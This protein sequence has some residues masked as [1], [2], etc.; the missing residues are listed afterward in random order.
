MSRQGFSKNS[1]VKI[2]GRI[3]SNLTDSDV[4]VSFLQSNKVFGKKFRR[5]KGQVLM[6]VLVFA[7]IGVLLLTALTSWA[8]ANVRVSKESFY[9]EQAIQIAEAG[10]DYYRWHLAHASQDFQDGTGTTTPY[11]HDFF[12][13]DGVKIGTFTLEIVP[14]IVGSTVVTIRSTGRV[15]SYPSVYRKI[16]T[17]LAIP[18]LAKYSI[19][20]NADIRFGAGT[21]VFG[22]IHSNGGI[23]FDGVAHNIVSSSR[24]TYDDPDHTGGNEYAVHT[25]MSPIDALPPAALSN[26]ADVFQAGRQMSVP[27]FDFTGLTSDLATIKTNAV[28]AG[29]YF[30]SSGAQG[31]LIVLKTNDTFDLYKVNSL[32]SPASNCTNSSNQ[33]GWGTWSIG[34]S[35]SSKTFLLNYSIPANG[36]IFVEDNVWV[37]G[38]ID[39]AR[40]TIASGKFP[41]NPATR[42]SITVN[43]NLL[44]TNYDSQDVLALIA[45]NNFNVGMVS[46][47]TLRIDAAI[48]AQNGRAGRYYYGGPG[49]NTC[50]PYHSR[51][52]ITLYGAIA[53]NQRYGFAYTD[54]T[55]YN[56]RN[57]VYDAN[58]LY[59]PPPSFPLT[60]DQYS[61]ISWQEIR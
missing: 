36:L 32:V 8:V 39:S 6:Q 45:Q 16:E 42:T 33:S 31:Y 53:T 48:V 61:T 13:K 30:A 15:D 18:S 34:S 46:A 22:P 20:A 25:H 12:D 49:S 44:Y 51:N 59:A 2:F 14:P 41:D 4:C 40:V 54:G 57:I 37:E 9:R 17:K 11:V 5:A 60:S 58:L 52:T 38:Q 35:G 50:Q 7:S 28:S 1:P 23:R 55:G 3:G 24:D 47:D 26:R 19:V 43:N 29:R 10:V 56:I 21:E 27:S